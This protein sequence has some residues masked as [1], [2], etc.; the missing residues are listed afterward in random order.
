MLLQLSSGNT[1]CAHGV[2][3]IDIQSGFVRKLLG[4]IGLSVPNRLG[5]AAVYHAVS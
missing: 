4:E 3:I 5:E 1:F 2:E